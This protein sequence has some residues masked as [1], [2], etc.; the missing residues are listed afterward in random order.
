MRERP[1]DVRAQLAWARELTS[2][3]AAP[4]RDLDE[5]EAFV[6]ELRA[7]DGMDAEQAMQAYCLVLLNLNDFLSVD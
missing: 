7:R 4:A 2:G 5:A 1:D 6:A 3:R